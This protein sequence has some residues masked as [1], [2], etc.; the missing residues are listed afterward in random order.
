MKKTCY[1]VFRKS[2]AGLPIIFP[3]IEQHRARK[4]RSLDLWR[5]TGIP[6]RIFNGTMFVPVLLRGAP[7]PKGPPGK[8]GPQG[9]QG[10]QGHTGPKGNKGERGRRGK[11]GPIG[12]HGI[13]GDP[14]R[15]GMPGSRGADGKVGAKGEKGD[16]GDRGLT[17]IKGE[18]VA[19][20][21]ITVPPSDQTVVSPGTATFS[22]EA[23][24]NPKPTVTILPKGKKMDERYKDIG[25]GMLE[26]SNV[27][28]QDHGEIECTAKSVIGE[29]RK[30][31]DLKVL[32]EYGKSS[33]Q[34]FPRQVGHQRR[35]YENLR[36]SQN[37][38]MKKRFP[39]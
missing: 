32:G 23:T 21:K 33:G 20:P 29:D 26:I 25:E 35:G 10:P 7:G 28:S 14:G 13:K 1:S 19:V 2:L 16:R 12:I 38:Y 37:S 4:R 36:C 9:P 24:G 34:K 5:M 18:S 15:I 11:P 6:N 31:A 3:V 22:C 39:P 17:G 27:T 8:E 30:K